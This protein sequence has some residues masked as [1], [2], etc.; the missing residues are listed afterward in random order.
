TLT[1]TYGISRKKV[2]PN[3]RKLARPLPGAARDR[4]GKQLLPHE[5]ALFGAPRDRED[6]AADVL[7]VLVE[8]VVDAELFLQHHELLRRVPLEGDE[9]EA[10]FEL[11]EALVDAV[12]ERVAAAEDLQATVF[13]RR[14]EPH[15]RIGRDH[16][17][18][19][20]ARLLER[21]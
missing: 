5:A 13:L 1:K 15:V 3:L 7:D 2:Q 18:A 17:F 21:Q 12:G 9:E 6:G 11:A 14:G 19:V 10:G 4:S 16:R 8:R 20:G